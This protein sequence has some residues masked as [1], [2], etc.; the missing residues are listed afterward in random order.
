MRNAGKYFLGALLLI[1]IISNEFICYSA[2]T[3]IAAIKS[4]AAGDSHSVILTENGIVY[5]FGLNTYGQL[6]YDT[7]GIFNNVPLKVT[8]I[9]N[10]KEIY[11]GSSQTFAVKQDG[12]VWGWGCNEKGQLGITTTTIVN[13]PALIK[14]IDNISSIACGESQTVALKKDGTVWA[15]GE[16]KYGQLGNGTG[17][18]TAT[19]VQV[20]GLT[21][22]INIASFGSHSV[23]VKKDGSVW[24]WGTNFYKELC[25]T[26]TIIK[27]PKKIDAVSNA[28]AASIG[29]CHILILLNDGSVLCG[30]DNSDSQ[31]GLKAGKD[32]VVEAGKL[33]ALGYN[34]FRPQDQQAFSNDVKLGSISSYGSH[35]LAIDTEGKLYTWG[36]YGIP[37]LYRDY[38]GQWNSNIIK[39]VSG[40]N[41]VIILKK[42]GTICT[43][44]ANSV[45]QIGNKDRIV[46]LVFSMLDLNFNNTETVLATSKNTLKPIKVFLEGKEL[47]FDSYSIIRDGSVLVPFRQLLEGLGAKVSWNEKDMVASATL[48]KTA[49]RIPLNSSTVY[50]NGNKVK[51]TTPSITIN[52]RILIPARFVSEN[53]NK[54]V[55]WFENSE[56]RSVIIYDNSSPIK[57][58]AANLDK[59]KK[60]AKAIQ[61]QLSSRNGI[62]DKTTYTMEEL[63]Q[64]KLV[65]SYIENPFTNET[66]YSYN[67]CLKTDNGYV[68][69]TPVLMYTEFDET[70]RQTWYEIDRY[71]RKKTYKSN[72]VG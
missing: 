21:D 32:S 12:S 10:V 29:Q 63:I 17:K 38:P 18:D 58:H 48:G 3:S 25:S 55:E 34:T 62:Y 59:L 61:Y 56:E 26:E 64:N 19:P 60:A 50:V 44:G 20:V 1:C 24:V 15:W 28:K 4:I 57:M 9:D 37:N 36:S 72:A 41:H 33:Y 6:G 54:Y 52:N 16:N 7:P 69:A 5:T 30:G 40:I 13:T 68:L 51:I 71:G 47:T 66:K 45:G 31:L 67:I 46:Y 8:G 35:N 42:D 23:A 39:A 43:I 2:E 49:I 70:I 11:A 27:T 14:G 65:D 53:L 22:V